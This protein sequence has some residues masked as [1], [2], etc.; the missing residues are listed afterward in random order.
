MLTVDVDV[1]HGSLLGDFVQVVLDFS[2]IWDGVN[3]QDVGQVGEGRDGALGF[4]AVWAVVFGEDHH[5]VLADQLVD[6]G[7]CSVGNHSGGRSKEVTS[8]G[9]EHEARKGCGCV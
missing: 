7:L 5:G 6:F 3:L 1:R 2:A 9:V 8:E 4:G